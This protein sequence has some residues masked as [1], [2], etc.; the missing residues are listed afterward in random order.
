MTT[1]DESD[2]GA[3]Q[4][5][6]QKNLSEKAIVGFGWTSL[7]MGAQAIVQIAALILLARLLSPEDFGLFA[8][9]MVVGGFCAIF[10]EIG[11]GPAIVQRK[12]LE[13][14]HVRSGFTLAVLLSIGAALLVWSLAPA[15]ARF[16]GM[17]ELSNI[18]RLMVIG[19]PLQG[20]SSIANSMALRA[21]KFRWLAKIEA[22]AFAIG[23]VIVAPI[24]TLFDLGV[25]A[26]VGAFLSQQVIRAG[27]LI[28]GQPHKKAPMLDLGAIG[29]LLYFGTGFSI[30]KVFNYFASQADNIVVGRWLGASALGVYGHAYQ[31]MQAPAMLIGQALDK[32]LFPTM[33]SVQD[34]KARLIRA[35]SSGVWACALIVLPLSAVV[36]ILATEIVLILLGERW[37]EVAVPLRILACAMLFRT[38]YKISDTIVRATGAVYARALRQVIFAGAVLIA[39]IIGQR[40]GLAGVAFGVFAALAL[41]FLMM[42][43]LSLRLTGMTWAAFGQAHI[44]GALFGTGI[45]MTSFLG[46]QTLYQFEIGPLATVAIVSLIATISAVGMLFLWPRVLIGDKNQRLLEALGNVA[47]KWLGGVVDQLQR[48]VAK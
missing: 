7:L 33:A 21:F 47:P 18:L 12:N 39:A 35:Y 14:R 42:A 2:T 10:S 6:H 45:A 36:A 30:A 17:S 48:R 38:S 4:S 5:P 44:P 24:I 20:I 8:A 11:I 40:F 27:L 29:D 1:P 25:M 3:T 43:H 26:L 23:Y 34:D 15:I 9:A 28:K 31:L 19:F 22:L 37:I 32:V 46:A 13:D 16:F 41:N